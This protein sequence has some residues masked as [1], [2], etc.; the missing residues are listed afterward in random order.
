MCWLFL[1]NQ[2]KAHCRL[3]GSKM[4]NNRKRKTVLV[5]VGPTAVGKTDLAIELAKA[6]EGEI[7]SADSRLFYRGMDIGTAKPTLQQMSVV[8]HHLIDCAEPQEI[9]SLAIYREK[10]TEIIKDIFERGKTPIIVGGTGQYI[11]AITEGWVLPPQQP[12]EIMRVVL[13]NW[14]NVIGEGEIYKKLAIIDPE[15]AKEIDPTNV[16]RTIRALEVIFLTGLRF[17][18]LRKK[19]RPEFNY[20]IIGLARPRMELYERIDQRVEEMFKLG[21][22]VETKKLMEKGLTSN[23]PNLSAIGYREVAAYLNGELTL[24]EA[25]RD[26]KRKTREFVRRQRNWFKPDDPAIHWH[27]INPNTLQEIIQELRVGIELDKNG[28]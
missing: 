17:S 10:V 22:I 25:K 13:Q 8:T 23:H 9:W 7:V 24:D 28:G 21:L 5:V 1:E 2:A 11:R 20:W 4:L 27:E 19:A 15:A 14:A 26:M 6:V 3:S 18:D 16:R 12:D